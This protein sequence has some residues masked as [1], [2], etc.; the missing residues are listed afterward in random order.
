MVVKRISGV[1]VTLSTFTF[2]P[3]VTYLHVLEN[4]ICNFCKRKKLS[5]CLELRHRGGAGGAAPLIPNLG[6]ED[7]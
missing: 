1:G 5:L 7:S 6:T 4:K 3:N 2:Y